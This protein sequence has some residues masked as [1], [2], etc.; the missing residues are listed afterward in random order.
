MIDQ[1]ATE[2]LRKTVKALIDEGKVK[3]VIGWEVKDKNNYPSPLFVES[4]DELDDLVIS[5]VYTPNV[6][7]F[8]NDE[9]SRIQQAE[10]L[11]KRGKG[12]EPDRRPVGIVVR[13]CDGRSLAKLIQE[14][15]VPRE[16]VYIIG[17]PCRGVL[18]PKKTSA[19]AGKKGK[20]I[21][22]ENNGKV[23]VFVDGEEAGELDRKDLLADKCLECE[24]PNPPIYDELVREEKQKSPVDVYGSEK[25]GNVEKIEQ[26][27]VEEREDFWEEQFSRCIRCYACRE[28]CP[29][30]YCE[31]C[32]VDPTSLALTP[33]TPAKEKAE[34]PKW[35][36]RANKT[37][38]N[39]FYHLTRAIHLAGRCTGCGECERV[40]PV[41]IP[42]LLLMKKVEKDVEEMF[43]YTAGISE[44][45]LLGTVSEEDPDDFIL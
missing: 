17:V 18:D 4:E 37:S 13:G 6:V 42:I 41:D 28:V 9:M 25:Y 38:E 12:E 1:K 36:T 20:I 26:K 30:C 19:S 10:E 23:T 3:Y 11:H 24:Y 14:N 45:S 27:S 2:S 31:E 5:E 34:K 33:F 22:E 32:A 44:E 43:H 35:I 39:A 21:Y 8:I 15:I 7:V 16:S 29:L 40:C